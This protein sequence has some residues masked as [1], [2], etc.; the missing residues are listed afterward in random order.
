MSLTFLSQAV[1]AMLALSVPLLGVL[2]A[3]RLAWCTYLALRAARFGLAGL[4]VAYLVFLAA[5]LAAVLGVWFAYGVAHS[6]K[7][8]W[9]D[10]L[11]IALTVLPFYAAC[12]AG[13]KIARK[14]QARLLDRKP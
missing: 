3:G 7:T 9:T 4:S 2:V 5:L 6:E 11:V 1:I 14:F 13:W 8:R 12:Y 10:L